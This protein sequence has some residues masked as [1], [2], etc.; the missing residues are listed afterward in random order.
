MS[1]LKTLVLLRH[2]KSS[3][4]DPSCRDHDRTLNKR[5]KRDAPRMAEW[6]CSQ[7]I[8]PDR[9]LSSTATRARKTAKA[10]QLASGENCSLLLE[11]SL[12]M[13]SPQEMLELVRHT[14]ESVRCLMLVGHNPGMEDLTAKL[15]GEWHRFPTATAAVFELDLDA[16]SDSSSR[17][18]AKLLALYRP[19]EIPMD[20]NP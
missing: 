8:R 11:G 6:L 9:I 2:A 5:G 1:K 12:Y 7:G 10:M 14:P 20:L 18:S 3:W 16:W 4:S 17:M 13:S 15:A 19:K